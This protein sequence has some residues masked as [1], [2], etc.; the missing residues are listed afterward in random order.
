MISR[1]PGGSD[2]RAANSWQPTTDESRDEGRSCQGLRLLPSPV[3]PSPLFSFA[4]FTLRSIMNAVRAQPLTRLAAIPDHDLL[5]SPSD[6]RLRAAASRPGFASILF[7]GVQAQPGKGT[8]NRQV[9]LYQP[10]SFNLQAVA[11]RTRV[12]VDAN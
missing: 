7:L 1:K 3:P 6:N 5:R 11:G 4:L 12:S 8:T 9:F 2:S 10:C